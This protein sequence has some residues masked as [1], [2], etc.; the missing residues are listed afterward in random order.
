MSCVAVVVADDELDHAREAS[1]RE[2]TRD[3]HP[4]VPVHRGVAAD[5]RPHEILGAAHQVAER[6]RV[7]LDRPEPRRRHPVEAERRREHR[8][9]RTPTSP[10]A[11]SGSASDAAEVVPVERPAPVLGRVEGQLAAAAGAATRKRYSSGSA[12]RRTRRSAPVR[13]PRRGPPLVIEGRPG[14][15][16]RGTPISVSIA[17]TCAGVAAVAPRGG[18]SVD[19][20]PRQ[21]LELRAPGRVEPVGGLELDGVALEEAERL[22]A[23]PRAQAGGRGSSRAPA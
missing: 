22:R 23:L 6:H 21:E 17:S 18:R 14:A 10:S 13:T 3:V 16:R 2:L 7:V 20:P 1:R 19:R 15:L 9:L 5:D 8:E 4:V 12:T 11:P